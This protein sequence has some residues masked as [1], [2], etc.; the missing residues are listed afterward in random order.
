MHFKEIH[1]IPQ[2]IEW[3]GDRRSIQE[4]DFQRFFG[5]TLSKS[6]YKHLKDKVFE[7]YCSPKQWGGVLCSYFLLE[8]QN[9]YDQLI[10]K[11]LSLMEKFPQ[12]I[13]EINGKDHPHVTWRYLRECNE[14]LWTKAWNSLRENAYHQFSVLDPWINYSFFFKGINV[15]PQGSKQKSYILYLKPL[16]QTE[17]A[18]KELGRV[19]CPLFNLSE[20]PNFFPHITLGKVRD[21]EH[22]FNTSVF[23][24]IQDVWNHEEWS[25]NFD[26][27]LFFRHLDHEGSFPVFGVAVPDFQLSRIQKEQSS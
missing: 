5:R 12:E 18:L 15:L 27:A 22:F 24:E 7:Y 21:S 20:D 9:A 25:F 11:T 4:N 17:K 8:K 13:L 19:L 14:A 23:S 10:Q 1:F 16:P 2:F 3:L 26:H 6:L